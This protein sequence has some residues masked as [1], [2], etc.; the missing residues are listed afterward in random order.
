MMMK[1]PFRELLPV[2]PLELTVRVPA[3]A[4]VGTVRLLTAAMTPAVRRA[5]NGMLQ[6]TVPQVLAHEVV[7]I[8]F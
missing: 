1:G 3:D 4:R 6:V 2:G 8:D 7:A 5:Q